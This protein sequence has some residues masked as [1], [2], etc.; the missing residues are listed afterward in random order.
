MHPAFAYAHKRY[1]KVAGRWSVWLLVLH[2]SM[3]HVRLHVISTRSILACRACRCG[4]LVQPCGRCAQLSMPAGPLHCS[5]KLAVVVGVCVGLVVG[6]IVVLL[7]VAVKSRD[8]RGCMLISRARVTV[9]RTRGGRSRWW[10]WYTLC[11]LFPTGR[12]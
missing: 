9:I 3:R 1:Q 10:G 4:M 7:A 12:Q 8:V 2:H 5:C 6:C 11:H